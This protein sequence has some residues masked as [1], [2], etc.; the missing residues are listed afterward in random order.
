[1]I[2]LQAPTFLLPTALH[3]ADQNPIRVGARAYGDWRSDSAGVRRLIRSSDLPPPYAT[4]SAGNGPTI[5]T[6]P[7]GT[8]LRVLPGFKASLLATGLHTPRLVRVAP[9][10]DIFIAESYSNQIRV[11]RVADGSSTPQRD[12]VFAT[13]LNLPFGIN[14]Y[15]PGPDPQFVYIA[16]TDSVVRF[17]Y[18]NGNLHS[19]G[20]AETVVKDLPGG[21]HLRGGGHWTRDVIF[22]PDGKKM[23]VSVGSL[24]N[25]DNGLLRLFGYEKDRADVLQYNPDGSGLRIFAA[26]IRNCVGMATNPNTGEL[27]CSTNERDGLGDNLPP[28]Y[29]TSVRDGGFYGWPWYYIGGHEDPRHA[30]ERPDLKD[31]VIVPDVLIQPHSAPLEMV[32]YE[33]SQ[34]PHEYDGDAFVAAHGSWNRSRRTG[35]KII[36][37]IMRDGRPTGEYDDFITG[38]VA[39]DGSV[40]GRPVGVAV[41]P[42]G[43][44][45]LTEDAHGT[46][47]KISYAGPR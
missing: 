14:F 46:A 16:N 4:P 38:F 42:D 34:F 6:P 37:V 47:W 29:I 30:S 36:R 25:D 18:C 21:G 13:G 35:Y 2:L 26:G 15:P 31:E 11:L 39:A 7:P 12:E 45:I 10:G 22:S 20:P 43:S 17:P 28:D 40:W 3:A 19:R 27:W 1:M 9:N 41:S 23:F 32:F 33:G 8:T 5:V 24:T 44:L